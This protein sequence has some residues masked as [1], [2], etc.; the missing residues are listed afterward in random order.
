M[1][2]CSKL[3][4]AG[5]T[6]ALVLSL[7]VGGASARSF[8]LTEQRFDAKWAGLRF[9]VGGNTIECALT[10]EG[11]FH[12]ATISKVENALVGHVSRA[13]FAGATCTG[14]HATVLSATLPW[15]VQYAGFRGRLPAINS[16]NIKLIGAAFAV[17]P[18]GTLRCLARTEVNNPAGLIAS[19]NASGQATSLTADETAEIPLTGELEFCRFGGEG[20]FGGVTTSLTR[21][22]RT[23]L[24][25]V[26]LI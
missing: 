19:L 9:I 5:L 1:P 15:H 26:S 17:Q 25:T 20:H 7:A 4:F 2:K 3:L 11:S 10:L 16:I 23:E 21:L 8:R 18:E 13:S 12:S 24:I 22:A 6:A 14:G